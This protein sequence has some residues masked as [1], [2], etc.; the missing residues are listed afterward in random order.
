LVRRVQRFRLG[1]VALPRA[2]TPDVLPGTQLGHSSAY[3]HSACITSRGCGGRAPLM[4][5]GSLRRVPPDVA[6]PGTAEVHRADFAVHDLHLDGLCGGKRCCADLWHAVKK[7]VAAACHD[8]QPTIGKRDEP[9][10]TRRVDCDLLTG[11]H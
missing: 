2:P 3:T 4:R 11:G 7:V 6:D 10:G 5:L 9:E 8:L 1:V